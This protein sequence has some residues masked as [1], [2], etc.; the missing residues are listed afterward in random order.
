MTTTSAVRLL[1]AGRLALGA[2]LLAAPDVVAKGWVGPELASSG[3]GGALIRGLG[4]RDVA[5]GAGLL[6]A[7]ESHTV[8]GWLIAGVLADA[9]DL[10]GTIAAGDALPR[11]GR[12]ATLALAGGAVVAG[13]VL[14]AKVSTD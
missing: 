11:N 8:R 13:L 7:G 6:A 3:A 1:A 12:I 9:S 5:L 2:G 4:G 14:A 10:A